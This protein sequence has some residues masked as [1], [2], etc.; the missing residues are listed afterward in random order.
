MLPK[1]SRRDFVKTSSA[2]AAFGIL[3][4]G[5]RA[6]SPNGRLRTAHIGVG[7]MGAGDLTRVSSHEKVE[8]AG[9]CDVDSK[10]LELARNQHPGARTFNDFLDSGLRRNDVLLGKHAFIKKH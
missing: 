9:L 4:S 2:F 6:A 7:G 10:R 1:L 8:V 3:S 5:S